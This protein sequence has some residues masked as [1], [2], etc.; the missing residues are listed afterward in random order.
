MEEID[1][2]EIFMNLESLNEVI[3]EQQ[4]AFQNWLE[5]E[6]EKGTSKKEILEMINDGWGYSNKPF[7]TI[8]QAERWFDALGI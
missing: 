8:K 5:A 4:L 6:Q 3:S 2:E 7:K 1:I